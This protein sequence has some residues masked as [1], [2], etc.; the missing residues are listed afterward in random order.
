MF[1]AQQKPILDQIFHRSQSA[2]LQTG[3]HTMMQFR[4]YRSANHVQDNTIC[5]QFDRGFLLYNEAALQH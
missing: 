5:L 4:Y 3:L 1:Y 2:Y